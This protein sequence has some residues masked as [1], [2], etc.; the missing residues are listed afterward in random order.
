MCK[1]SKNN[2]SNCLIP[3]QFPK[4]TKLPI[5]NPSNGWLRAVINAENNQMLYSLLIACFHTTAKT[6]P[7]AFLAVV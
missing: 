4:L 2:Y 6:C 7:L 5:A 1:G 3:G